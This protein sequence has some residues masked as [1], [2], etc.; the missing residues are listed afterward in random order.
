MNKKI[1]IIIC[2]ILVLIIGLFILLGCKN[3][4]E[5]NIAVN[6]TQ[7]VQNNEN[8]TNTNTSPNKGVEYD[9]KDGVL[10]QILDEEGNPKQTDFVIDGLIRF[11]RLFISSHSAFLLRFCP[12]RIRI[13]RFP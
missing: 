1:I 11:Q 4:K 8:I 5:D 13:S 10:T 3:K 7:S 9:Y 6:N 12:L 2:I